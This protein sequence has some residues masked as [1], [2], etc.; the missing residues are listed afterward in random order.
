MNYCFKSLYATILFAGSVFF[1]SGKFVNPINTPK[2]YFVI[3]ILL[4]AV[5]IAAIHKKKITFDVLS[6]KAILWGISISCFLQACYGLSQFVGWLPSNHSKFV[7]TGSFD[8]PAGFTAVLAMGFPIS[9]LLLLKTE[10][11]EKYSTIIILMVIAI[12]I[13]LSGSRTGILAII[14]SLVVFILFDTNIV[15]E[16]RQ[17]RYYKLL[18]VSILFCFVYGAS[19][20]YH[21]KIDSANGRVLIW[22]VSLE[23]IKE[24]PVFGYGFGM[25]QAKYMD[26]QAEYFKNNP[27]SKYAQLAD[28]VKHPFNEFI[29]VSVEFGIVGLI[30]LLSFHFLVLWKALKSKNKNREIILSGLTSFFVF[31]CFSYPLQYIAVWI[32]ITFYLTTFLPSKEIRINN[33]PISIIGRS[34]V[35]IT[36]S[37]LLFRVSQQVNAEIKWKTIAINSLRGNTEIMLPEYEKLYSTSLKPNPYFLYNYG[38]E[39]NFAGRYDKSIDILTV[40]QQHFNDYDLQMLLADNYYKKGETEKAIEIYRH[41]SFMIPCRFLPIYQLFEI[42]RKTEQKYMAV[43]CA[44]EILNKKIKIP[45]LTINLIKAAAVEYLKENEITFGNK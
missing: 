35:V 5:A 19:I 38:A 30:I 9:L 3:A 34:L 39:L 23:M 28:N 31:A 16:F 43:R 15:S 25:F 1:T 44:K 45:S 36:C 33:T 10:K 11:N 40:C 20:F 6:S 17:F 18:T 2:F 37:V 26:F 27:D 4:C 14:I 12:S 32:L 42:Y 22:K 7:I 8:N 29:K 41:A 13:L 24:K 21:K